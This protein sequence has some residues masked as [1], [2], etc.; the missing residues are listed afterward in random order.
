MAKELMEIGGFITEGAEIVNHDNS[1]SGN[2]TSASPLGVV[3]GY[4]ETVLWSGALTVG[5]TAQMSEPVSAFESYKFYLLGHERYLKTVN[6]FW[7]DGSSAGNEPYKVNPIIFQAGDGFFTINAGD[8]KWNTT[9][10]NL[11]YVTGYNKWM[12]YNSSTWNQINQN[13]DS[14]TIVKI[15]GI[16]RK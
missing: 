8:C 1:L 6:E 7:T 15:V 10:D 11:Q 2:G 4:N 3:P 5:N 12:P 14:P 13:T 9:W 16:N